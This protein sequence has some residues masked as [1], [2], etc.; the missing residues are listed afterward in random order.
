MDKKIN[1]YLCMS[2]CRSTYNVHIK[3]MSKNF[4]RKYFFVNKI[5]RYYN[6]KKNY[7]LK[8]PFFRLND[9]MYFFLLLLILN[10]KITENNTEK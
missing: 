9:K 8:I 5:L 1:A 7:M 6:F 10:D 3:R 4:L 2:A